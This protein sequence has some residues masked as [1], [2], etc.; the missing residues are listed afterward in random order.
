MVYKPIPYIEVYAEFLNKGIDKTGIR[1]FLLRG[2][3]SMVTAIIVE[4]DLRVYIP[5]EPEEDLR[6]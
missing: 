1:Y 2:T 3:T 4:K 6:V 5:D